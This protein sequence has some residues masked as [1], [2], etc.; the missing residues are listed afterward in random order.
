MEFIDFND[1]A[2]Y[3]QKKIEMITY[4]LQESGQIAKDVISNGRVVDQAFKFVFF[5]NKGD[6][7]KAVVNSNAA[8][9]RK[10]PEIPVLIKNGGG[11][12]DPTSSIDVYLQKIEFEVYG[13]CDRLDPIRDQWH[14]IELIF[15]YLCANLKGKTD[16][17]SGHTIK[18]DMSDYPVLNELENKHF[19]ALL[20]CNM[21][22]LMSAHLSN[23][24]KISIN[25]IQIPYV[26]FTEDVNIELIPDNKKTT[27]IKFMPNSY[28]YQLSVAGLY[29][30]DN[31][32]VNSMVT[33][34]TTGEIYKQVFGV[35]IIRNGEVLKNRN[36][37]IKSFQTIR[38]FGSVV[39]YKVTF[40]PALTEV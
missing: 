7:H 13:S 34:N 20:N 14:D 16:T 5:V 40:L 19:I 29:V 32:V 6:Y 38:N 37:Y 10:Y 17:F 11:I 2:S 28:I 3:F 30:T 23:M 39:A 1:V 22:V 27:E 24:D 26:N 25:G 36:M 4:D 9:D 12:Q 31:S 35:E 33:G 18:T 15:S 21:H 8:R